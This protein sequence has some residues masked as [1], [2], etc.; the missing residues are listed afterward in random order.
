MLIRDLFVIGVIT[1]A[2]APVVTAQYWGGMQELQPENVTIQG[3]FGISTA[4]GSGTIV[5]SSANGF[6]NSGP[7]TAGSGILSVYEKNVLGDWSLVETLIDP[8]LSGAGGARELVTI[9]G[10]RMIGTSFGFVLEYERRAGRWE[11]NG[12]TWAGSSPFNATDGFLFGMDLSGDTFIATFPNA[13]GGTNFDPKIKFFQ[14][15]ASGRWALDTVF[16]STGLG[17]PESS[18]LGGSPGGVA[19]EGDRAIV[20]APLYTEFGFQ[21]VGL[22]LCFVR[23]NGVWRHDQTLHY[24]EPILASPVGFYSVELSHGR[25]FVGAAASGPPQ[26]RGRG[27]VFIYGLQPNQGWVLEGSLEPVVEAGNPVEYGGFGY[28]IRWDPPLLAVGA[29][30]RSVAGFGPGDPGGGIGTIYVFQECDGLWNQRIGMTTPYG[31]PVNHFFAYNMDL[32]DGVLVAGAPYY[33]GGSQLGTA[34]VREVPVLSTGECWAIGRTVCA[35][36]SPTTVDCPCGVPPASEGRGCPNSAGSGARLEFHGGFHETYADRAVVSGLPP[37]AIV[38]LAHGLPA[39]APLP[40]V[41]RGG[42]VVCLDQVRPLHL[43]VADAGGVLQHDLLATP[44]TAGTFGLSLPVQA[45][46]RDPGPGPCGFM[47][48]ASQAVLLPLHPY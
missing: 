10:G 33:P 32:A 4:V 46:Y 3:R 45:L 5:V 8:F 31:W 14:R 48:N 20:S 37:G 35:P 24:P 36:A 13:L 2:T 27:K 42:G 39:Q 7:L 44:M 22:V 30:G 26:S 1:G 43:G 41:H 17:I 23:E 28:P 40:G 29:T 18:Q 15:S 9:D 34:F 25:L 19:I 16:T 12:A 38:V 6:L 11:F 21:Q 47:V